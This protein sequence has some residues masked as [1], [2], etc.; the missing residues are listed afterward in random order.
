[1]E[2]KTGTILQLAAVVAL[3]TGLEYYFYYAPDLSGRRVRAD[4]RLGAGA[5]ADI[6][7]ERPGEHHLK[8]IKQLTFGGENAEAYWSFDGKQICLQSTRDGHTADQ[9]YVMNADGSDPR[10]VSTGKGRCTCSY[11]SKD[12]S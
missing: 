12:G 10:M 6:G 3:L 5:A 8:N 1:M 11:F 7:L 9:I 2:K 4:S